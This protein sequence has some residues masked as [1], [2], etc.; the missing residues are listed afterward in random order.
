LSSNYDALR[1]A[2]RDALDQHLKQ[3]FAETAKEVGSPTQEVGSPTQEPT[4]PENHP[5]QSQTPG[6]TTDPRMPQQN[7]SASRWAEAS[8]ERQEAQRGLAE[9]EAG[10]VAEA[11]EKSPQADR[12][13]KPTER[14]AIDARQGLNAEHEAARQALDGHEQGGPSE[15]LDQ[16]AD[17]SRKPDDIER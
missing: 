5:S 10:Q 11:A 7:A 14:E 2:H 12:S 8:N 6:W 1:Q 9:H 13:Q 17:I 15:G 3:Q 4:R 16:S